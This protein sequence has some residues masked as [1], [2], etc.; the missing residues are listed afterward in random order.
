[1][2]FEPLPKAARAQVMAKV[3]LAFGVALVASSAVGQAS[4]ELGTPPPPSP[5]RPT[6]EARAEALRPQRVP[7]TFTPS[8]Y[9]D[10]KNGVSWRRCELGTNLAEGT[11]KCGGVAQRVT[12]VE[13]LEVV[14]ALNANAFEGHSDWRLPSATELRS[15]LLDDPKVASAGTPVSRG[16]ASAFGGY[17]L[18]TDNDKC[19]AAN[20][21]IYEVFASVNNASEDFFQSHRWLAD[22]SD[23]KTWQNPLAMNLVGNWGMNREGHCNLII[24]AFLEDQFDHKRQGVLRPHASLPVLVVRGGVPAQA[25]LEAKAALPSKAEILAQ[26]QRLGTAQVVAAGR[27]VQ[28]VQDYVRDVLG[29]ASDGGGSGT[30]ASEGRSSAEVTGGSKEYPYLCEFKCA[31]GQW[32][33]VESFG[34]SGG[35]AATRLHETVEKTC[36]AYGKVQDRGWGIECKSK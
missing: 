31:G 29:H 23:R 20:R 21:R 8:T 11:G 22:N 3:V 6:P 36:R 13:A 35:Q 17:F 19:T 34:R 12:W 1:V 27:V 16:S 26:S 7:P 25:W 10:N 4:F 18:K 9:T 28:R 2:D 24:Y 15:L 33:K 5:P 32:H 30:S 14:A